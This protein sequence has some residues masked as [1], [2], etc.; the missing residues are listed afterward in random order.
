MTSQGKIVGEAECANCVANYFGPGM[1]ARSTRRER[2]PLD[3]SVSDTVVC[4]GSESLWL[5]EIERDLSAS[6]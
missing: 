5:S 1:S 2:R 6:S 3:V 4:L